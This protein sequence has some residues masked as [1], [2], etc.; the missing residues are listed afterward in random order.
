MGFTILKLALAAG[1]ISFASWLSAKKPEA[2]GFLTAL[3][4]ISIIA[5]AFSYWQHH[6]LEQTTRYA[7]SILVAVPLSC[8]FFVPFFLTD[9]IALGFWSYWAMGLV[10]VIIAFYLHQ[11]I[12]SVL[13]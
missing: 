3:P 6:D 10:L 1:I 11:W 9:K 8:L 7:R 12:M 13:P 4:L 2:A 5:I